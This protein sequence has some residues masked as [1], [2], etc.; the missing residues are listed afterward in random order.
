MQSITSR[1]PVA[2]RCHRSLTEAD[3]GS[4]QQVN[5]FHKKITQIV[6]EST[7]QQLRPWESPHILPAFLI[8]GQVFVPPTLV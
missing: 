7:R 1:L 2:A 6:W 8:L 4:L 5:N 3:L